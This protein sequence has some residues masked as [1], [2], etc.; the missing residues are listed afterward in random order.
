MT[1]PTK[2]EMA[3]M[4]EQ[5]SGPD[6]ELDCLIA[7][8]VGRDIGRSRGA[9][10]DRR[11][12]AYT[13]CLIAAK[14]LTPDGWFIRVTQVRFGMWRVELWRGDKSVLTPPDVEA[15]ASSEERARVAANLRALAAQEDHHG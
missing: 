5:A 12:P 3:A 2:M 9:L 14:S 10:G 15:I 11:A 4:A 8:A 7:V 1:T 13:A 6:R